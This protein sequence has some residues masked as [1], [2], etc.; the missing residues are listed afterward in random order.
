MKT[1]AIT[2]VLFVIVLVA[3]VLLGPW[4]FSV[5]FL[6]IGLLSLDEFYRITNAD[7][8]NNT[9]I[10]D[11]SNIGIKVNRWAGIALGAALFI[12]LI[13]IHLKDATISV[14][15][16]CIPFITLA[17]WLELFRKQPNPFSSIAF[18][19][20]GV[21][22]AVLPFMFFFQLGF[23]EGDYNF[24]YPLGFLIML[25]ASDT[26]AYLAGRTFGKTKLFE[27]H[28]PKKTWEGSFGGLIISGLAAFILSRFF[29]GIETWQWLI[30]SVI[31]VVF[32]TYGDLTESML[33]RSYHI[34]DS[35]NIMPGHG[36]FLDRF[37]GLLLAA[38]LVYL[39]LLLSKGFGI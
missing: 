25:W 2:G 1:R 38:P 9:D 3:S 5:F 20:L 7:V 32:G 12:C 30:S 8:I 16:Y 19:F 31:I 22:Y 36:G 10:K 21:I 23:L 33:K 6:I 15:L 39:F 37:D 27:R 35:G 34:K 28:S 17:F 29:P 11:I 14:F 24:Q 4:V 18:T 26:G 13:L